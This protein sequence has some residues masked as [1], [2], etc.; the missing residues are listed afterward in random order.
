MI[1]TREAYQIVPA[2]N[3]SPTSFLTPPKHVAHTHRPALPTRYRPTSN[4]G[5]FWKHG[6]Q[7]LNIMF[8]Q[9]QLSVF[10][11]IGSPETLSSIYVHGV[12]DLP[13]GPR[14]IKIHQLESRATV[15][16]YHNV[17]IPNVSVNTPLLVKR[18][19]CCSEGLMTSVRCRKFPETT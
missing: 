2:H 16:F 3:L 5:A 10:R 18:L 4:K 11:S 6:V 17:R 9:N 14:P 7:H 8:S 12:S 19:E 1:I 13:Y 15:S